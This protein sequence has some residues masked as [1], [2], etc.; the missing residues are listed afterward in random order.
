MK[1]TNKEN[2]DTNPEQELSEI[3]FLKKELSYYQKDGLEGSYYALNYQ[4]NK[5]NDIIRTADISLT[6]KD[7]AFERFWIIL[8]QIKDVH[9]SIQ[10][11]KTIIFEDKDKNTAKK[12]SASFMDEMSEK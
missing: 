9:S 8:T 4:L 1:K 3:D 2:I 6:G 10:Q 11:L 5:L 7:K 12:Q